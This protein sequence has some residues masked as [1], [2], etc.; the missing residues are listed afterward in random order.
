MAGPSNNI[1]KRRGLTEQGCAHIAASTV[2]G[3]FWT[4][5]ASGGW[6][7]V[8]KTN[9]G[10]KSKPGIGIVSGNRACGGEDSLSACLNLL[11]TQNSAPSR[12]V[13]KSR[14]FGP[15]GRP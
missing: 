15:G 13:Q 10:R 11:A 8:K 12:Y 2:G 1:L 5:K 3:L 6:C 4:F 9:N 14:Q 7:W